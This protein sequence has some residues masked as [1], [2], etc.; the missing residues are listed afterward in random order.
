M[1][2]HLSASCARAQSASACRKL[3]VPLDT[4]QQHLRDRKALFIG[5]LRVLLGQ[6]WQ[7]VMTHGIVFLKVL[8]KRIWWPGICLSSELAF[9]EEP[10]IDPLA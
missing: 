8:L 5:V 1:R 9:L 6:V 7:L 10:N 2:A 3:I 4:F